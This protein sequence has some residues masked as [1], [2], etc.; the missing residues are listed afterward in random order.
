MHH[1]LEE[2]DRL[3]KQA[4]SDRCTAVLMEL[5]QELEKKI[6]HGRYSVPGGY[7]Q[8]QDDQGKTVEQYNLV[9]QKGIMVCLPVTLL[10]LS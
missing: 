1:K 4:S 6:Q 3:N 9:E 10:Y 5:F 7:Q 8:F 2:F